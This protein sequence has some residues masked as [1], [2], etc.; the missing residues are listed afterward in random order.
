MKGAVTSSEVPDVDEVMGEDAGASDYRLT[1]YTPEYRAK[2]TDILAAFQITPQPGVP[3]EE[4]GAAV[5]ATSSTG[6]WT[7]VWTDE[8]TSLDRGKGRCYDIKPVAGEE[9]QYI[10][11][12]AYPL[13]L[14]EEGSVT[15]ML[16]SIAIVGN[17]FGFKALRA[18]RLEDLRIPPAYSKTFIGPPHGI[19]VERDKLN[20][21][22]RPLLGWDVQSSQN[23]ACLPRIMVERFINVFAVD[24]ILQKMMKTIFADIPITRKPTEVRMGK[25]K[26]NPIGWMARVVT[27]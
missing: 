22:E 1:Y 7:T 9:N 18:L 12:V 26:G 20:K 14:F 24:L 2:D 25:G 3:A 21:Y 10:A 15:N 23:W 8:L 27:G 16:T 13:D 4:A 19:Q 11:Y 6:T 17:V 5:A